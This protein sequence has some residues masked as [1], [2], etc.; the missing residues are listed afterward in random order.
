MQEIERDLIEKAAR[1][2]KKAFEEIYCLSSGYVFTLALRVT[3]NREDAEE[4]AQDVFVRIYK[5]LKKFQFKSSFKTWIYRIAINTG[6]NYI[7][8][9]KRHNNIKELFGNFNH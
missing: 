1:G 5:N 4:A 3:N 9:Q 2:D 7:K 6:I 8:S